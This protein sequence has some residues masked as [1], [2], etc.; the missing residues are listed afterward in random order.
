MLMVAGLAGAAA[1]ATGEI[2]AINCISES[3]AAPCTD[4]F[5]LVDPHGVSLS[6]DA[7]RVL[8]ASTGSDAV[9]VFERNR[10]SGAIKQLAKNGDASN[11]CI[12]EAGAG[13]CKVGHGLD[14]PMGVTAP[15]DDKNV[16]AASTGSNAVDILARDSE[17]SQLKQ[18]SGTKGCINEGGTDGCAP[19]H[20]LTGAASIVMNPAGGNNFVYV[21]GDHT[22]AAFKRNLSTGELTQMGPDTS[23]RP[24]T[25]GCVNDDGSDNCTDGYV[26]GT[27]NALAFSSDGKFMYAAVSGDGVGAVLLFSRQPQGPLTYIGCYNNDGSNGCVNV[28]GIDSPQGVALDGG[29]RTLYVTSSGTDAIAVFSRNQLT[30]ALTQLAAPNGCINQSGA[31]GCTAMALPLTGIHS[32]AVADNGKSANVTSDEGVTNFI[33]GK[34]TGILTTLG[35]PFGCIT[36]T[37]NA[38][39]C[40]VAGGGLDGSW[41]IVLSSSKKHVYVVGNGEAAINALQKH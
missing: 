14:A 2:T 3:G 6:G 24:L 16:Y 19:G 15:H 27:V 33:R 20:G 11:G 8:V 38:G 28:N 22:I 12:S 18:D 25:D 5:A 37:G 13:G 26:P 30:G 17:W 1:R 23:G 7:S 10:D 35:A 31:D 41:G 4:G 21:G 29:K 32:F 39:A 40:D 34:K 36:D 9:A